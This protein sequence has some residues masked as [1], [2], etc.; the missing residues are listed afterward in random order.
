MENIPWPLIAMMILVIGLYTYK[1]SIRTYNRR[2][3][4]W[5]F[6]WAMVLAVVGVWTLNT[7][8]SN[9][10]VRSIGIWVGSPLAILGVPLISFV[11]D[12]FQRKEESRSERF[13]RIATEVIIL[14]PLWFIGS[15]FV[16]ILLGWITI[17]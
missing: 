4:R 1:E 17:D 10:D 2:K 14:V 12:Q 6:A 9:P 11:Y 7:D 3:Q 16:Q 8:W 15:I 13:I 5:L